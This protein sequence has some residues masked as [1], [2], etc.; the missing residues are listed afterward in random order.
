MER[1]GDKAVLRVADSGPGI[2]SADLPMIFERFYRGRAAGKNQGSGLGLALCREIAR[3]HGGEI[4]AS[5]RPGGGSEFV[6]TLPLARSG[7]LPLGPAGTGRI[8]RH[9][10]VR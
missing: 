10:N 8:I 6:A 3:L 4:T 9:L 5:S 1:N 2:E 7:T